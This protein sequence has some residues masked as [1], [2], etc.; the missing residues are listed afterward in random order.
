MGARGRRVL[1]T[2]PRL[3]GDAIGF[4][5]VSTWRPSKAC[6]CGAQFATS[7][8]FPHMVRST[9][10][11]KI[12]TATQRVNFRGV[13]GISFWKWVFWILSMLNGSFWKRRRYGRVLWTSNKRFY[14]VTMISDDFGGWQNSLEVCYFSRSGWRARVLF[15]LAS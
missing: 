8:N 11:S 12:L 1:R 15:V 14:K 6:I 5:R 13:N 3:C 2:H 7:V 9:P 4:V 10:L